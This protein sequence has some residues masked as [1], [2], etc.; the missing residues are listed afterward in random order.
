M[1]EDE[2]T[3]GD[4][5][6]YAGNNERA[7]IYAG[8]DFSITGELRTN[9]RVG[10]KANPGDYDANAD[11]LVVYSSAHGGMTIATP[12]TSEG[13]IYF[14]DGTVSAAQYAGRIEYHHDG[15]KLFLGAGATTSLVVTSGQNVGIGTIPS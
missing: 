14:S 9:D 8:G 1:P 13:K 10:I 12:G 3:A 7:R 2:E 4:V 6:F 15:D 11:D 5:V